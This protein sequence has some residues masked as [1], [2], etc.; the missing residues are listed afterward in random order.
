MHLQRYSFIMSF[1]MLSEKTHFFLQDVEI[2]NFY[3]KIWGNRI[4][5]THTQRC[6]VNHEK[7]DNKLNYLDLFVFVFF[8]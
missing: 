7:S 8:N 5:Q 2:H 3:R 6:D 4:Q 1:L